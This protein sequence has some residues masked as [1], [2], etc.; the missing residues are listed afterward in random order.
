MTHDRRMTERAQTL[1]KQATPQEKHLWYDF[2]S[3]YPVPFRRQRVF[4]GYIADFYC[5]RAKLV[6][7]LDGAQ[8]HETRQAAYDAE[9]TQWLH[10]HGI[11]VLRFDNRQVEKEFSS[12]CAQIDLAVSKSIPL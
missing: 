2:L 4:E 5:P 10:A 12:V 3:T 9:R 6:I 11:E 8:H 7:E 1:R